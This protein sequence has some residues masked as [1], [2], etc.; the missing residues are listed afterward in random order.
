M[1]LPI[2]PVG[3]IQAM[4]QL[5]VAMKKQTTANKIRRYQERLDSLLDRDLHLLRIDLP[6]V[7]VRDITRGIT[8]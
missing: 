5:G 4:F 1:P 2:D 8:T 3:I 7:D 6:Q